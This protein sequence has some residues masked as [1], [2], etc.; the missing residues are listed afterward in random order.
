MHLPP[1]NRM[2][3][4]LSR[5]DEHLV[6]Q[7]ILDI[8]ALETGE[9]LTECSWSQV[10]VGKGEWSVPTSWTDDLPRTG[11]FKF[12]YVCKA[13]DSRNDDA[14]RAQ[15]VSKLSWLSKQVPSQGRK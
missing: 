5:R 2:E 11:R 6:V 10:S 7:Y 12:T 15:A 9:N 14:R 13:S 1:Q 8:A 4:D 3:F